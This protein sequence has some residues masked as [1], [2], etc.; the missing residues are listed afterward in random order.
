[1]SDRFEDKLLEIKRKILKKYGILNDKLSSDLTDLILSS[2]NY[3]K[4]TV[5]KFNGGLDK[6]DNDT[7]KRFGELINDRIKGIEKE[8]KKSTDSD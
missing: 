3:G 6:A 1:M 2:I 7:I 4:Y 5:M 8:L